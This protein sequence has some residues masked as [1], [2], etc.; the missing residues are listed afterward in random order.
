MIKVSPLNGGD[1]KINKTGAK[2]QDELV[3]LNSPFTDVGR[4]RSPEAAILADD[5]SLK[6]ANV[7]DE[8]QKLWTP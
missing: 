1:K 7:M 4:P 8:K 6:M 3:G 5:F 2:A